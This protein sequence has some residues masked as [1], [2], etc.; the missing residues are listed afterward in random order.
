MKSTPNRDIVSRFDMIGLE[1]CREDGNGNLSDATIY[2][3]W[4]I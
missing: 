4:F 1:L 3:L 2:V